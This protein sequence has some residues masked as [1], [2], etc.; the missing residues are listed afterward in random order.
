M[1]AAISAFMGLKSSFNAQSWNRI[2]ACFKENRR[3][4]EPGFR[5]S[6][7]DFKMNRDH[8]FLQ[9]V[10][11]SSQYCAVHNHVRIVLVNEEA[12]KIT[13]HDILDGI[14]IVRPH[15]NIDVLV[16]E[17]HLPPYHKYIYSCQIIE[18]DCNCSDHDPICH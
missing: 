4:N 16:W 2:I 13:L 3:Q 9:R 18:R 5:K 11:D 15:E 14:G 6:L 1:N 12:P 7:S 8:I 17:S 10:V